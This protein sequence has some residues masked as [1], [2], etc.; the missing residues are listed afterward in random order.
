MKQNK[1]ITQ[2]R[3]ARWYTDTEKDINNKKHALIN[4]VT[5]FYC[6]HTLDP[7]NP[8]PPDGIS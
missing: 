2:Y 1:N 3:L 4:P 5:V 6:I 8:F 7:F